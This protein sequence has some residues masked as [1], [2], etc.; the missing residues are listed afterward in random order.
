M[1]PKDDVTPNSKPHTQQ[2]S[3]HVDDLK[4]HTDHHQASEEM[5]D[6]ASETCTLRPIPQTSETKKIDRVHKQ[7]QQPKTH[8]NHRKQQKEKTSPI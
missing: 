1:Q 8:M 6:A 4:Q 3:K 7:Q 5:D 2:P